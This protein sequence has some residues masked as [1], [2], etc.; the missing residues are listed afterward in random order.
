MK[1]SRILIL[2]LAILILAGC[3]RQ[4]P[5]MNVN[6]NTGQPPVANNNLNADQPPVLNENINSN[7]PSAGCGL[8]NCHGLEIK[9]GPN[10]AQICTELYQLGDKCRRHAT[11]GFINGQCQLL[12]NPNFDV[13]K[14]CV[15]ACETQNQNEAVKQFECESRCN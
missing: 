6:L 3:V 9:C 12:P 10:P 7:P 2:T 8:E 4:T 14:A 1:K 13:C 11:C 5:P 15:S